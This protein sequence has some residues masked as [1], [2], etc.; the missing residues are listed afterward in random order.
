MWRGHEQ[1]TDNDVLSGAHYRYQLQQQAIMPLVAT[2]YALNV[3][4]NYAKQ[5]YVC[6]WGPARQL[7]RL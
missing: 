5:R 1:A 4:L 7:R 3:G 6:L 2:T